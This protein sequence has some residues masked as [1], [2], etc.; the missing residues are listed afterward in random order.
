MIDKQ[1]GMNKNRLM[2]LLQAALLGAFAALLLYFPADAMEAAR[3]ACRLWAEHVMPALFPY[4]VVSS[5]LTQAAGGGWLTAPLSMLGGSPS[6][7]RL[8]AAAGAPPRRMQALGALCATVSPSYI[9]GA[10]S[11]GARLLLSHWLSGLI[12][13]A[14]VWALARRGVSRTAG[15]T[16]PRPAS[17]GLAEVIREATLA[18]LTVCGAM[19]LFMVGS[20]LLF[21]A[22][23]LP[24]GLQTAVACCLEMAGGCARILALGLSR[25]EAMPLLCAAISFGGL[26]IFMQNAIFLKPAG[27][28][29]R[30]QLASR[31]VHAALAYAVCAAS[32]MLWN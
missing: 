22:F 24:V 16:K 6:G 12:T 14:L 19:T 10:L 2:R 25:R 1:Y 32:Y 18:V 28:N 15:E 29:L 31:V 20:A 7:A 11:G 27:V 21:R 9:L 17:T 30:I 3:A 5:L 23:P 13:F 8:V 4:M 26:S